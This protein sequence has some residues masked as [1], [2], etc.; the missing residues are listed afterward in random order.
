MEIPL[1]VVILAKNEEVRIE[2]CIK[3]VFGWAG[4][5][6]IIDD[7]SLDRT[8]EIARRYAGKIFVRKMDLEGRQ[9]NF[10]ALQAKFDW[11]LMLDCD[12]RLTAELKGEISETLK[13][14]TD[15]TAAYWITKINYLGA[16]RLR[17]GGW[18]NPH[19][20]LYDKRYVRWSEAE[21]DVVHPGIKIS[22]GYR[23]GN[24]KSAYVHYNFANLEDFIKKDN[25]YSTLEALKW[26]ISGRKMGL[27]R[28]LWRTQDRFFRRLLNRKGYKDGFYGF[29]AA[30]IGASHELFTYAKYREIKENNFYLDRLGK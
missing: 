5:V 24:L 30:F 16:R 25:R 22:E 11:V 15:N 4:E 6:I 17:Y 7:E 13:E 20:K 8:V 23:G 12:E 28:A 29:V 18:S 1:S 21:Y 26:H 14:Q 2:E 10:G 27:G 9:R 3:S 19:V